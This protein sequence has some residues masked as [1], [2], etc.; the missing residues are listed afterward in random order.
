LSWNSL[1]RPGWPRTR[2][3]TCLCLPSAGIKG[4]LTQDLK[5]ASSCFLMAC[6]KPGK[7]SVESCHNVGLLAHDGQVNEDGQPDLGKARDYYSR[8]CD[9]G[10]AASCFNLSAMFLQGAPGFPKDM[11]LA[12]KYSMK[13]CDLGHVWACANASRMYKLGDGVDKDEAKAEVLKNRARQL[14]KEQQ[15]NVQPLTFG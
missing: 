12:C 7:K 14:H 8:A 2:K 4:G 1:C 13:A 9:G 11:G 3:P 5:A 10:Y 6:E 15:K